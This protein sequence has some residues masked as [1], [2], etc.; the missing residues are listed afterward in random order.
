MRIGCADS[1]F[2]VLGLEFE[3][4]VLDRKPDV[5]AGVPACP[6]WGLGK[7]GYQ[8]PSNEPGRQGRQ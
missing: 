5:V 2:S 6:D 7:M 8:N 1:H 4:W 3:F